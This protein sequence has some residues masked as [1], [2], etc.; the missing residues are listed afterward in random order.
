MRRKCALES[1]RSLSNQTAWPP[2][3]GPAMRETL[4]AHEA[5]TPNVPDAGP[6]KAPNGKGEHKERPCQVCDACRAMG[7]AMNEQLDSRSPSEKQEVSLDRDEQALAFLRRVLPPES[8]GLYCLFKKKTAGHAQTQH[9]ST[10]EELWR[11]T[12]EFERGCKGN[13]YYSLASYRD[14]SSREAANAQELR[15]FFADI[16]IDEKKAREGTCHATPMEANAAIK[17]FRAATGWPAPLIV[18]SG[19]GIHLY[20][21]L[22]EPLPVH[23]W[24]PLAEKLKRLFRVHGLMADP[25]VTADAARVLRVPGTVNRKDPRAPIEVSIQ[26]DPRD[27]GPYDLK[28]LLPALNAVETGLV[29]NFGPRP[30]YLRAVTGRIDMNTARIGIE[31]EPFPPSDATLVAEACAQIKFM[32]DERGVMP[33]PEWRGCLSVLKFCQ[34]GEKLAHDWSKGDD[35]YTHGET[36]RK[37]DAIE[38]PHKCETFAGLNRR[39]EGCPHKGKII[40]PIE[41]GRPAVAVAPAPVGLKWVLGQGGRIRERNYPNAMTAIT[42]LGIECRHDVFHD[43][44]LVAGNVL[45]DAGPEL[46]DAIVRAVRDKVITRFGFDP[47]KDNI[48]EALERSCERVRFDPMLDYLSSVKWDGQHRL[49]QWLITYLGAENTPLNRAF[50]RKTLIAAVRRVRQP[51]CKFD[52]MLVL[53]GSQGIGKSTALK[54]LA[55]GDENFSDQKLDL[56]DPKMQQEAVS[57]VFIYEIAELE[58]TRKAEVETVKSFLSRTSDNVRPAYGRF[59]VDR[60]RRCIFVGTTNAG[61]HDGYLQDP[62]GNRR[63][64]PVECQTIDLEA[65]RRDVDQL[66][67][68]AVMAEAKGEPLEIGGDLYEAA[69]VQQGLRCRQDGWLEMLEDVS[70]TRVETEDGLVER[71]ASKTLLTHHLGLSG[72]QINDFHT[73]RLGRV[74]RQLG[75]QGPEKMR[76]G[77]KE[78]GR[79]VQGYRRKAQA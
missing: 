54:I 60:P 18:G 7:S 51:G 26:Q 32:R 33:E 46:S 48:Q 10:I 74:M 22:S 61:K 9:V 30:G 40:S 37:L 29:I 79:P 34:G 36:Q 2:V 49:D 23:V 12:Q 76:A 47:G 77:G 17:K 55:G 69:A 44:K 45:D 25:S 4:N 50:G 1:P 65:L 68:E 62:S 16:D 6:V 66:W 72:A 64:W 52:Y 70:G 15:S 73:K 14:N 13:I 3:T 56:H 75:W 8:A 57:G 21:P 59:R 42:A 78:E 41:L 53:E 28:M 24:K 35:R 31:P 63:F 67:A 27:V 5:R 38:G 20:W 43:R 39:C 71:I 11:Q 58:S 19:H